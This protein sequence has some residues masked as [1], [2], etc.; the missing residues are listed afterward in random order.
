MINYF[1]RF[2][3]KIFLSKTKSKLKISVINKKKLFKKKTKKN[4]I[5]KMILIKPVKN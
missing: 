3:F 1:L 2:Y 5:K 4:L